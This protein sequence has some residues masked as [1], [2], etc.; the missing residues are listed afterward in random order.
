MELLERAR[1]FAAEAH[2]DQQ[3]G[4]Q[5]YTVHLAAVEGVLRRFGATEEADVELLVSAWLHDVI[6]DTGRTRE[7]LQV[8]FG[9][10]VAELVWAVTDEPG[11]NREERHARTFPK[12]RSVPGA[13][14]LK[15]ADRIANLEAAREHRRDLFQMYRREHADFESQLRRPGEHD[16]MWEHL[17]SLL[18]SAPG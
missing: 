10:R 6:E 17:A 15:L 9:E 5:P 12:T 13:V 8:S 11:A 14:R 4:A 18:G 3:Y 2:R 1:A 16:E 7:E